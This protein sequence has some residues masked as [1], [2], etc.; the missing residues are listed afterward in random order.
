ME[1]ELIELTFN[2]LP[3]AVIYNALTFL[4]AKDVASFISTCQRVNEIA[5][6]D[7]IWQG[8]TK[9]QLGIDYKHFAEHPSLN[10]SKWRDKFQAAKRVHERWMHTA[11]DTASGRTVGVPGAPLEC[12]VAGVNQPM[13]CVNHLGGNAFLVSG[14]SG[15]V[16][17]ITPE[18]S[19][20][21]GPVKLVCKASQEANTTAGLAQSVSA[22]ILHAS[23]HA[24]AKDVTVLN[25]SFTG[26]VSLSRVNWWELSQLHALPAK[27]LKAILKDR[28]V[29]FEGLTEKADFLAKVK[30]W[31]ALPLLSRMVRL[32]G[33]LGTVVSC[34]HH[35]DLGVTGG[36][37]GIVRVWR[38]GVH[39]EV[40]SISRAQAGLCLAEL[41]TSST[42]SGVD[43]VQY[44]PR[45]G[46]AYSGDKAGV[47][48]V[49]DL[50]A[51][52]RLACILDSASQ[53]KGSRSASARPWIWCI[54]SSSTWADSMG[55]EPSLPREGNGE[56]EADWGTRVAR[57]HSRGGSA[58]AAAAALGSQEGPARVVEPT[59]LYEAVEATKSG[60][61]DDS[62][63]GPERETVHAFLSS[64]SAATAGSG[65][66]TATAAAS[67]SSQDL[68]A[69]TFHG[70][71]RTL[72]TGDTDGWCRLWDLRACGSARH[73]VKC[74]QAVRLPPPAREMT[75][76]TGWAGSPIAGMTT[77]FGHGRFIT[78][79]FDGC[80]RVWDLRRF[81]VVQT[82]SAHG[83]AAGLAIPSPSSST[84]RGGGMP[85]STGHQAAADRL[86]R[87]D[88]SPDMILAGSMDG[89]VLGWD[90]WPE[91]RR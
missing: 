28:G 83:S 76:L 43:S 7:R 20:P 1:D 4:A 55:H 82:L 53:T 36:N 18:R 69:N 15:S 74:V 80:A 11:R 44:D 41:R 64:A 31:D 13:F 40:S 12:H 77:M 52:G 34:S 87:V 9:S 5:A 46:L 27:R 73:S 57:A 14:G 84:R 38:L 88:V 60:E 2:D 85:G 58:T 8:L 81:T 65:N 3:D 75:D 91:G 47:V 51:G 66:S 23:P 39:A 79:S 54:R 63:N 72:L 56:V 70:D 22:S 71:G 42:S 29:S 32:Q 26:D 21:D 25:G 17:L 35:G 48:N 33:H 78:S 45:W 86:C 30:A 19:S 61:D 10:D 62:M 16:H 68:E 59:W 90:L 89:G 50:A 67:I 6:D 49:W 24:P 37:E